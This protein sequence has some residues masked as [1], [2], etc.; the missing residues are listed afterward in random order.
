MP[1]DFTVL[2]K[3][4]PI[5]IGSVNR[6]ITMK[7]QTRP[8]GNLPP[9]LILEIS[10]HLPPHSIV[11]LALT[12]KDFYYNN[13]Q[14]RNIWTR[15]LSEDDT[16][17]R[18]SDEYLKIVRPDICNPERLMLLNLLH[19]ELPR[20]CLC[21]YC[22][23]LIPAGFF[24]LSKLGT[25]PWVEWPYYDT[26]NVCD[27]SPGPARPYLHYSDWYVHVGFWNV[28]RVMHR[29]PRGKGHGDSPETITLDL[30]WRLHRYRG[31][32]RAAWL[33]KLDTEPILV[34]QNLIWHVCQRMIFSN[35]YLLRLE[36]RGIDSSDLIGTLV[37]RHL[38]HC[39]CPDPQNEALLASLFSYMISNL[40]P[41]TGV[42]VSKYLSKSTSIFKCRYCL[43]ESLCTLKKHAH[44]GLE[45]ILDTWTNLGQCEHA[46]NP[47]WLAAT[48]RDNAI[49]PGH[50][51][52]HARYVAT[53][54]REYPGR[55]IDLEESGSAI[56]H[57]SMRYHFKRWRDLAPEP[58]LRL[59]ICA[60]DWLVRTAKFLLSYHQGF[61]CWIFNIP[62]RLFGLGLFEFL[63]L[64]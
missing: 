61:L 19:R 37:S 35:D 16:V 2:R 31:H 4:Q 60:F 14:L 42:S 44:R 1:T 45:L 55:Q 51:I 50:I 3:H 18:R 13:P 39:Q 48:S 28:Q 24:G 63:G 17:D 52:D 20:R 34:G 27:Y 15:Q 33:R 26:R 32:C 8:I 7:D 6:K 62:F 43:T 58:K 53:L 11:A 22:L 57:S 23:K 46:F 30:D 29:Y 59:L 12:C 25:N 47:E 38:K 9:E 40:Q 21:D 10:D 54:E 41:G 64:R 5:T 56:G 49:Y 36:S